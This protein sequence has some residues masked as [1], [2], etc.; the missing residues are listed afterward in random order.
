MKDKIFIKNDSPR[1]GICAGQWLYYFC[2]IEIK[3]DTG[4]Q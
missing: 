3:G 4:A 1:A 2:L